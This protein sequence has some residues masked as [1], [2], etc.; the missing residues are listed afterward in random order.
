M[1][2]FHIYASMILITYKFIFFFFPNYLFNWFV[3]T[4]FFFFYY[5]QSERRTT[6]KHVPSSAGHTYSF[7]SVNLLRIVLSLRSI[8]SSSDRWRLRFMV[9]D[10]ERMCES[11]AR[12]W[13]AVD[14]RTRNLSRTQ[15]DLWLRFPWTFVI[16]TVTKS[17]WQV[18]LTT[19]H[20]TVLAFIPPVSVVFLFQIP[21]PG[22]SLGTS[23][24]SNFTR[25]PLQLSIPLSRESKLKKKKEKRNKT[26]DFRQVYSFIATKVTAR[27]SFV[28]ISFY[29]IPRDERELKKTPT[30]R[31]E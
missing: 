14:P 3:Q 6:K 25:N 20:W 4:T 5:W 24:F 1:Q 8:S 18:L 15:T 19:Q 21:P 13:R 17:L 22:T 23:V 11:R 31:C 12:S 9:A 16:R 30:V 7:Y 27:V 29:K 26:Q 2:V 28:V 10:G